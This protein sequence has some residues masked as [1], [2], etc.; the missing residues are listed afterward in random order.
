M[1]RGSNNHEKVNN[2]MAFLRS[3]LRLR[4]LGVPKY[5]LGLEVARSKDG[6]MLCQ[7]KYWLDLLNEYGMLGAKLVKTSIDVNNHLNASGEDMLPNETCNRKWE[8]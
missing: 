7:R 1:V 4:E 3:K 8:S 6:I 2:V 5:F